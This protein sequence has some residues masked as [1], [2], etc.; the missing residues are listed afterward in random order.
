M[1]KRRLGIKFQEEIQEALKMLDC[2]K[3][4][5]DH[6]GELFCSECG[7]LHKQPKRKAD[8]IAFYRRTGWLLECKEIRATRLPWSRLERHQEDALLKAARSGFGLV[9]IKQ[10][11]KPRPPRVFALA[12]QDW[13]HLRDEGH[14]GASLPLADDQRP[15]LVYE[16]RRECVRQNVILGT[17]NPPVW[18]LKPILDDLIALLGC[19]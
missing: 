5:L 16:L 14:L 2:W 19:E 6:I 13:Q 12:I 7:A 8:L 1:A 9:L 4:N 18:N 10:I 17:P 3:H 15:P 11:L